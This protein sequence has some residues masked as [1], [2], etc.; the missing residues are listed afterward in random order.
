MCAQVLDGTL[1][2][3]AVLPRT[4]EVAERY[5]VDVGTANRALRLL[6]E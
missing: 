3:G 1:A 5:G 6:R 4:A 2:P